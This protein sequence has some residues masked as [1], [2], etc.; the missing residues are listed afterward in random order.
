MVED[1]DVESYA[2]YLTVNEELQSN[3]Y[4]WFFPAENN[5]HNAPV[6]L[7]LQGGPGASSLYAT[8]Y[9][10]GPFF[11]TKDLKLEKRSHY[12]SQELNVIYI[13]NPV[14]TGFSFTNHESGYA[15][16][17]TD[18]GRDLYEALSQFFQ[19]FPEY[20]MNNFF[21]SGESYAGKYIPSL[22]HTIHEKNPMADEKINL[23]GIAIGDGLVDPKNMMVYSDYLYQHGL[24]DDNLYATLKAMEN[25]TVKYIDEQNFH[26]ATAEFWNILGVLHE[27]SGPIDQYDYLKAGVDDISENATSAYLNQT[28]V[29][30][31]LHVGNLSYSNGEKVQNKL[32][33]DVMKSVA[34][35]LE[36]L[37]DE[38]RVM[39]YNGQLDIICAYPLT[40]NYIKLLKWSGAEE[41]RKAPRKQ[42]FVGE[43]LA[44]YTKSVGNFT[45]VLVRNAGHMVPADQPLWALDLITRFTNNIPFDRR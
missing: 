32:Y 43:D 29:R 13:D 28:S 1:D 42:W 5:R 39:L 35:W 15:T 10:N 23:K 4:F 7:W 30:R 37:M 36:E 24:T 18:V 11:I 27:V 6:V 38:Y 8:F 22:A 25:K 20:R 12:W 26:N 17:Q 2:G 14:G 19:L 31:S 40:V 21:I 9:E 44:G 45:E 16:N 34:P 33:E 41:Y 3:M